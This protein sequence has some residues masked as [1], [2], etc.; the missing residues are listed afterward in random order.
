[1]KNADEVVAD[2]PRDEFDEPEP[3][4]SIENML[5]KI[6]KTPR[7][8]DVPRPRHAIVRHGRVGSVTDF[9]AA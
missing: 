1:V 8:L 9:A 4:K 7:V 3:R 2:R 5:P 6:C